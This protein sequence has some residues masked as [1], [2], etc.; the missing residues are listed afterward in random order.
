MADAFFSQKIRTLFNRFD[1]DKNGMIEVDDFNK[2]SATLAAIGKLNAERSAALAKSLLKIWETYFLPADVNNDGSVEVPEL[3]A[4]MKSV[5]IY[6][7]IYIYILI[8]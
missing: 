3:V 1:I 6:I 4:Y 8:I 7:Y 5:I 2:W